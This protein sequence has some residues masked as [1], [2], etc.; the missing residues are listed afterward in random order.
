MGKQKNRINPFV[1]GKYVSD[2]FFCDREQET[3]LMK[4]QILN[5]RNMTLIADRRI[6]KSGLISHVFAQTDIQKNYC[7]ISVDL[8][9]TGCL[10]EMVCLFSKEVYRQ[11]RSQSSSWGDKFF[12]VI[13]SL[14]MGFKLDSITGSPTFDVGIGDIAAPAMT[15]EQIFDFLEMSEKPCI[16][17]FDE[18]QQISTYPE[19]NVEAL[20]RTYIQRCKKT[21]FVFA[22]SRKHLMTQMFLSPAKPFYRSTI[23]LGL[24]PIACETYIDFA[25]S[26]FQKGDKGISAEVVKQVYDSFHGVTWYMQLMMNEMYVLTHEGEVCD[27]EMF[28]MALQNILRIQEPF[29]R[30]LLANLPM[31]QKE[32]LL[33][34]VKDGIVGNIMSNEFI[35]KHSLQS[36]SSVQSALNGLQDKELVVCEAG[37][38]WRVY[39]TFLEQYVIHS[40]EWAI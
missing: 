19:K 7:T 25:K 3:E 12:Q 23:N 26:M 2:E 1:I 8:Y 6:G 37:G 13:S 40:N 36:S 39:D 33:A 21:Q 9:S 16:V 20:L 28:D 11:V 10:A 27:M 35:R 5:G 31:R 18:F 17:A 15:I 32:L 34:I 30:E 22:G 38:A 14:R 4:K 29:Y 24:E